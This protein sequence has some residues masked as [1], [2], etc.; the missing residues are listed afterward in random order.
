MGYFV[1][2][3]QLQSGSTGVVL[4]T[5]S[6]MNRPGSPVFGMIRYNTTLPGIEYFN[7][8]GWLYLADNSG[9]TYVVDSFTANGTSAIY[10]MSLQVSDPA[11]IIVFVGSI[12]QTPGGNSTPQAYS[13]DG[14]Y[15][16]TFASPPPN[17]M[18][19]NII[20]TDTP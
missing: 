16:I 18:T 11:Q 19:I 2:N 15:D 6:S 20:H 9:T 14:G 12:Y 3:R 7:G 8:S 10:T 1:K 17:G 4:P 13:V 5:G